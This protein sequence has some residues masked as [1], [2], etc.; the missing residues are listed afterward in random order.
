MK[1]LDPNL[2]KKKKKP[3]KVLNEE[4]TDR[5]VKQQLEKI[6]KLKDPIDPWP[7]GTLLR[8]RLKA[9]HKFIGV[10]YCTLISY[11]RLWSYKLSPTERTCQVLV[12]NA[13]GTRVVE[14]RTAWLVPVG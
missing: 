3:K 4:L 11:E 10:S 12:H 2:V 13:D 1:I 14:V 5:N 9:H 8:P 6:E 7:I